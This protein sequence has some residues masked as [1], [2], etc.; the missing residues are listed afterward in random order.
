LTRNDSNHFGL[1]EGG[2]DHKNP[3]SVE[4]HCS[5]NELDIN[6]PVAEKFRSWQ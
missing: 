1:V 6:L 5:T 2:D 3:G 4:C